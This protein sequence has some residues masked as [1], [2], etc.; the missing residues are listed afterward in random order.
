MMMMM[1][2]VQ[3]GAKAAVTAYGMLLAAC[4]GMA[5]GQDAII[6]IVAGAF[7]T[8]AEDVVGRRDGSEAGGG[9]WVGA[10]VVRM[11]DE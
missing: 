7:G 1:M 8:V 11:V 3:V 10:V 6:P 2:I 9:V 4:C 5:M